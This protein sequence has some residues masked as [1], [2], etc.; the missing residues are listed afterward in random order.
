MSDVLVVGA[1]AAGLATAE[2]LRRRGFGGTVRL[3]GAEPHPPYDRP[4]LSKQVLVGDWDS[5]RTVLRPPGALA[6]LGI[7]TLLG[8]SAVSLD[9]ARHEVVLDDGTPLPYTDLV[10]ATGLTPRRLGPFTDLAGVHTVRTLEDAGRLRA[11]LAGAE[12]L[13]VIGAGVLGCE[14]AASARRL[15]LEVTVI[16]PAPVPM[17]DRLGPRIG[18]MLAGLHRDHGIVMMSGASAEAPVVSGGRVA[19][20]R[21]SKGVV[22]AD[23]VVVAVGSTPATRWLEGSG[24]VLDDGVVCDARC[25]AA[26]HVYAVGDVARWWHEGQRRY[27]RLENRS[28]ATE[29]ALA[30]ADN[31]LG[32]GRPYVPVPY[33]W[34]DQHGIRMQV[35]GHPA[36]ADRIRIVE[37]APDPRKFVAVA[38]SGERTVG[39]VGWNSARGLRRAR[40]LLTGGGRAH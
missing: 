38:E 11:A 5:G 22:E 2:S 30:V 25:R 12:R 15:G 21:T 31:I 6:E 7:E 13:A 23:V 40:A 10:V 8:R 26:E 1:S 17:A 9:T 29:Q 20:V 14:I 33:F 18:G 32:A 28:N 36:E 39:V 19:G 37:Q 24:L 3:V 35:L 16:D 27:V 34:T 4:P